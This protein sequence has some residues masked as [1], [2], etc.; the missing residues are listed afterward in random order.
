MG[1]P[2]H[3]HIW[4]INTIPVTIILLDHFFYP[5]ADEW[6]D[7]FCLLAY[8]WDDFFCL[9]ADEW[10]DFFCLLV[11]ICCR[12]LFSIFSVAVVC[13]RQLFSILKRIKYHFMS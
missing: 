7:F 6:D 2:C 8:E 1:F 5:L 10:D 4:G 3:N 13:C 11:G 12:Q 9:L